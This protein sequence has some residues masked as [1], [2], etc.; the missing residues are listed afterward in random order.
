MNIDLAILLE[1]GEGQYTEFKSVYDRT[2]PE[3]PAPRDFKRIAKDIAISLA[4]FAN[5]DG[6]TLLLGVE[7]NGTVTGVPFS[8]KQLDSLC[9]ISADSWRQHVPY[10]NLSTIQIPLSSFLRLN[11]NLMCSV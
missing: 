3:K 6:G 10:K 4:E 1:R 9:G 11:H 8:Q 7:D 2:I 5:A